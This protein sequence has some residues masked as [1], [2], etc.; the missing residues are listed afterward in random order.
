M[1]E[2]NQNHQK[3]DLDPVSDKDLFEEVASRLKRIYRKGHGKDFLFEFFSFIFHEGKFQGV[4]ENPRFRFYKSNQG[5]VG[6]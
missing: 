2:Q 4:E 3:P 6:L 1:K 5:L